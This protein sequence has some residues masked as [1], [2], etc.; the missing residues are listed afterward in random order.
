MVFHPGVVL[1]THYH[2]G[3]VHLWTLSGRWNY[4]EYPDQP[5]R[6]GSYLFEPGSSIHTLSVP[7]DHPVSERTLFRPLAAA[8]LLRVDQ[9]WILRAIVLINIGQLA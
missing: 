1:P 4:L 6:A 7:A 8:L 9:A 5:Q 2:T 3:T